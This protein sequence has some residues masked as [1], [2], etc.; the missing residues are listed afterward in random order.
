MALRRLH[1][2]PKRR[3]WGWA[4]SNRRQPSAPTVGFLLRCPDKARSVQMTPLSQS[5]VYCV[6]RDMTT[7][8]GAAGCRD[9]STSTASP[10]RDP[11]YRHHRQPDPT[12]MSGV[13]DA[14]PGA[15]RR[16]R[17]GPLNPLRLFIALRARISM[18]PLGPRCFPTE[19]RL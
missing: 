18:R 17:K 12:E 15:P 4:P 16:A 9:T 10:T 6:L 1:R 5:T 7:W 11:G 2:R 19:R 13:Q 8:F 14:L 3:E